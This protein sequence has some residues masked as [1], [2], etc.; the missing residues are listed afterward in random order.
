MNFQVREKLIEMVLDK[1]KSV[2]SASRTFKIK[3]STAKMI[4]S[5]A[6]LARNFNKN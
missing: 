1:N 3:P 6:L 5:K 4:V 2:A